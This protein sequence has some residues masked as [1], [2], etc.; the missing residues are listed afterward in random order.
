GR[1]EPVHGPLQGCCLRGRARRL[2][3]GR[4]VGGRRRGHGGRIGGGRGRRRV[5]LEGRGNGAHGQGRGRRG[6]R[7]LRVEPRY[8]QLR[9]PGIEAQHGTA[10]RGGGEN[11]EGEAEDRADAHA[12]PGT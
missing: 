2:G 7:R 11:Q 9:G 5:G 12:L 1:G 8:A 4:G 10:H 6:E 3:R